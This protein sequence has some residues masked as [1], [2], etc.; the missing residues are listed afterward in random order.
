MPH[1]PPPIA[2]SASTTTHLLNNTPKTSHE[3][4]R[5]LRQPTNK[6]AA[7]E[8]S[9][10]SCNVK[11]Q[12]IW[13]TCAQVASKMILARTTPLDKVKKPSE[14]LSLLC[15]DLNY[16]KQVSKCDGSRKWVAELSTPM[17]YSSTTIPS[18]PHPSSAQ[19]NKDFEMILHGM[20]AECCLLAGE[21]LG[22]GYASLS[23][24]ASYVK[25]RV[26]FKRQIGMN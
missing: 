21:A 1:L 12:K 25:T 5:L 24:A 19:K 17:K 18:P 10:G 7:R 2:T 26:V 3:P 14:C 20:N 23:K 13:I 15:I 4:D 8:N 11:D 9:D 22:L 6:K 16:N